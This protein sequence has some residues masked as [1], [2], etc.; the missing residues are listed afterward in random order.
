[1][2]K[3]I[4][5]GVLFTTAALSVAFAMAYQALAVPQ[6]Y[7]SREASL[8]KGRPVCAK[9]ETPEGELPCSRLASLT[10]YASNWSH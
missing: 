2:L 8:S 3:T 5:N 6:V 4:I 1:V 7:F 9:I 10:T